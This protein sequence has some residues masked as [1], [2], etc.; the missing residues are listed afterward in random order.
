MHFETEGDVAGCLVLFLVCC[1]NWCG[2]DY[3]GFDMQHAESNVKCAMYAKAEQRGLMLYYSPNS[4]YEM[5]RRVLYCGLTVEQPTR[6]PF[7]NQYALSSCLGVV[8][9]FNYSF[10]L[11][12]SNLLCVAKVFKNTCS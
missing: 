5:L 10:Q 2:S 7:C 12:L 8:L 3:H 1:L 6:C 4:T 11:F 9:Y